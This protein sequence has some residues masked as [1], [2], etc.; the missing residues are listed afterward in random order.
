ME[1]E[2]V[3]ERLPWLLGG[4]L[5]AEEARDV[6]GHVAGCHRCRG[7]LSDTQLAWAIFAA[8]VPE[9]DLLAIATG[10]VT[11]SPAAAEH[12]TGCASCAEERE[13]L[14]EG[15]AALESSGELEPV[16]SGEHSDAMP[17]RA[18]L[19]GAGR[20]G[21][22]AANRPTWRPNSLAAAAGL[23]AALGLA[24]WSWEWRRAARIEVRVAAQER[25]LRS[26]L[27]AIAAESRELRQRL[28]AAGQD[29]LPQINT[30][31]VEVFAEEPHRGR[32]GEPTVAEVAENRLVTLI[33]S[34]TRDRDSASEDLQ[35]ELLAGERVLWS[36]G[37]L[38]RD[39]AGGYTVSLPGRLLPE[40]LVRIRVFSHQDGRQTLLDAYTIRV[41]RPTPGSSG[42][43]S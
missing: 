38:A 35:V 21:A 29:G 40:G 24:G 41:R 23:M 1:C 19:G 32:E 36:A 7:E 26:Q 22:T 17:M 16:S 33:L 15:W 42:R 12:L 30:P 25:E 2:E 4:S 43:N 3:V 14:K 39:K 37:G 8:H 27:D 9:E 34:S 10:K 13:L 31:V 18:D 11:P 5:G 20:P 28:D 6:R